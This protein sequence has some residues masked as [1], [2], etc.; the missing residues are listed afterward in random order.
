MKDL[1]AGSSTHLLNGVFEIGRTKILLI[2]K[3]NIT[4]YETVVSIGLDE[5]CR[6]KAKNASNTKK[7]SL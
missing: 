3:Q 1:A 4:T 2:T 6:F 7:T 5:E